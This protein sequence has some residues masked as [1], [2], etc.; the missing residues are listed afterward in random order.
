MGVNT[1]RLI[2]R[3]D[4]APTLE[5]IRE[6]F[7]LI[8]CLFCDRPMLSLR[9]A[10]AELRKDIDTDIDIILNFNVFHWEYSLPEGK[11]VLQRNQLIQTQEDQT[12]SFLGDSNFI[13]RNGHRIFVKFK[14][15]KRKKMKFYRELINSLI[16]HIWYSEGK[17]KKYLLKLSRLYFEDHLLGYLQSKRAL[18]MMNMGEALELTLEQQTIPAEDYIGHM[19][20]AFDRFYRDSV[21]LQQK[22]E[23]PIYVR[24]ASI[25]TARKIREVFQLLE[26]APAASRESNGSFPSVT[27]CSASF[28]FAELEKLHHQ[29]PQYSGTLLLAAH[30]CQSEP[31][32]ERNAGFYYQQMFEVIAKKD[33]RAY[34]FVY[35]E[36]GRY[37][38]RMENNWNRAFRYYKRAWDL[39]PLNYRAYF[40]LACHEAKANRLAAA[41]MSFD[42]IIQ[43]IRR[44]FSGG[45]T[46]V[47]ENLSLTCIQ[48]LFKS[49]IWMWKI[50]LAV[51][52]YSRAQVYLRNAWEAAEAFQENACLQKIYGVG[53]NTWKELERYHKKSRPVNLLYQI[54]RS[55]LDE[56]DTLYSIE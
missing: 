18:R 15:P 56:A 44:N 17:T 34:S 16:S 40:K 21:K 2:R 32:Q 7:Y 9:E 43:I 20:L 11:D 29:D 42:D 45:E 10:E 46:I 23:V 37:I 3:V 28:L 41:L 4:D 31:S 47:W 26:K 22:P 54:V 19:L 50:Y 35:Y 38:E 33:Q 36:Y 55:W 27:Y 25:N 14:P 48:Y 12:V 6:F 8:G 5:V 39:D 30:V 49:Y 1:L 13:L 52:N 51:G 24:H 53:T